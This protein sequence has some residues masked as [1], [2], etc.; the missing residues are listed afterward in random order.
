MSAAGQGGT[1]FGDNQKLDMQAGEYKIHVPNIELPGSS[2]EP[3][4]DVSHSCFCHG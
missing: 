4:P 3:D 2:V 1:G